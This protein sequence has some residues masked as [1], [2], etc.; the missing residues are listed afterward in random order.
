MHVNYYGM[1]ASMCE[2]REWADAFLVHIWNDFDREKESLPNMRSYGQSSLYLGLVSIW[3]RQSASSIDGLHLTS[4]AG[5]L[6][7][8]HK[9]ICY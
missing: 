8:Q 4:M 7:V 5:M 9:G 1:H 3:R 6:E 2:K